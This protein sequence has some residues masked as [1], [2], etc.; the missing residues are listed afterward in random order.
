VAALARALAASRCATAG[1]KG[2]A[3]VGRSVSS[4]RGGTSLS[5]RAATAVGRR[6]DPAQ[7]AALT[8]ALHPPLPRIPSST[9]SPKGGGPFPFGG[10]NMQS[11]FEQIFRDD[12]QYGAFFRGEAIVET[13]IN[14]SFMV[15][16]PARVRICLARMEELRSGGA[17]RGR[18]SFR[19]A[20]AA[21]AA[22]GR[23]LLLWRP[24][25]AAAAATAR[26]ACSRAATCSFLHVPR[27][28]AGG[29]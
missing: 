5:A 15:R 16:G 4:K 10:F 14:L 28:P 29:R 25:A 23:R 20:S 26:A 21:R 27:A 13:T 24:S 1:G 2:R 22:P 11:I 8:Y 7:A 17:H 3:Q 19:Q 6:D 12:P 18:A 9:R